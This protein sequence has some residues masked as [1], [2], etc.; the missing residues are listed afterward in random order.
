MLNAH[1]C[2][3]VLKELLH[4]T[5]NMR[6]HGRMEDITELMQTYRECVR[7][8][9]N[10]YFRTLEDGDRV[11]PDVEDALFSA[12]VIPNTCV[13]KTVSCLRSV[14]KI[15]P[16]GTLVLWGRIKGSIWNWQ[17]LRLHDTDIELHFRGYFDWDEEGYRDWQYYEAVIVEYAAAPEL[18]G[19]R[20]L[21]EVSHAK[22]FLVVPQEAEA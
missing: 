4:R 21:L 3:N 1:P 14:P 22:V 2:Y 12:L 20:M 17:E 6:L 18:R 19:A 15:A 8:T 13:H 11:F 10:T 7:H 16:L 5:K 9:W